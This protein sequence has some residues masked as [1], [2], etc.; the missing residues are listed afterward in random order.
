MA[1][2]TTRGG[3]ALQSGSM[4]VS[5]VDK[6][7]GYGNALGLESSNGGYDDLTQETIASTRRCRGKKQTKKWDFLSETSFLRHHFSLSTATASKAPSKTTEKKAGKKTS[8]AAAPTDD[9]KKGKKMRKKTRK[10]TYSPYIYKVLKQ[11]H[12]DICILNKAMAILNSYANNI[13]EGIASEASIGGRGQERRTPEEEGR[14]TAQTQG[15]VVQ[16]GVLPSCA[17]EGMEGSGL[18]M[19]V[20]TP[21]ALY[22]Y[23]LALGRVVL[24]WRPDADAEAGD[25]RDGLGGLKRRAALLSWPRTPHPRLS[26]WR[27][28]LYM[29]STSS[30]P[31]LSPP[32]PPSVPTGVSPSSYT[33]GPRNRA[34]YGD[35]STSTPF[36]G[37]SP[38]HADSSPCLP[39]A[40][41][42]RSTT[43][44]G[45]HKG[46][47]VG[48]LHRREHRRLLLLQRARRQRVETSAVGLFAASPGSPG[49]AALASVSSALSASSSA[50][51][52]AGGAAGAWVR[53]GR[54]AVGGT[55]LGAGVW[56]MWP[57][58]PGME[59]GT[60]PES[61]AA[62]AQLY[63]E[64]RRG[65]TGTVV[66][67]VAG[68]RDR[69][70]ITLA[71]R[72]RTV[73]IFAVNP[74][75][76]RADVRSHLGA[77]VQDGEV[78]TGDEQPTERAAKREATRAAKAECVAKKA[79]R[80]ERRK[81]REAEEEGRPRKRR[82]R[83]AK[84]VVYS[85]AEEEE[86]EEEEVAGEDA[87]DDDK[88]T[89][90][91]PQ[92]ALVTGARLKDYQLEGLQWMVS[93]DQ[94]G[95]S[96]LIWSG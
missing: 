44:D 51:L 15:P 60:S 32:L 94:Q 6:G 66:E 30:P 31:Q 83:G 42:R 3:A 4:V 86:E 75:G 45:R 18:E 54:A 13:F 84:A 73:H 9:E 28:H 33:N 38:P 35:P 5:Q 1:L 19:E 65:C 40:P 50:L 20:L 92:P 93:L 62:P 7:L 71:T 26:F 87:E 39:R 61:L 48:P 25:K 64:L 57:E 43:R 12:P 49:A 74:Y 46:G 85:D 82:R 11:V 63:E 2:R 22:I 55:G 72:R 47:E 77:R 29:H 91:F 59:L 10:E 58:S 34:F 37:T 88:D 53:A 69:R 52:G 14:L 80:A 67:G 70:F 89:S 16:A 76:G 8:K 23:S 79:E 56:G 24:V 78:V 90:A 17:K 36:M 96:Q 81:Q 95:I 27:D 68:V 21:H 41:A